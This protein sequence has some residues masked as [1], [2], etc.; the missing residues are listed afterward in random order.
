MLESTASLGQA[1]ISG[2]WN[3]FSIP[4]PGFNFTFRQMWL[5][6]AICVLSLYV[7]KRLLGAGSSGGTSS[8]TGS[9][10]NPKISKARKDDEF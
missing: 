4:V 6:F 2:V 7:C 5:G 1:L 8:R 10:R 9:T 3:L